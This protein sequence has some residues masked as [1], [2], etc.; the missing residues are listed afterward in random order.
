MP[1]VGAV[2]QTTPLSTCP[3]LRA[4][5]ANLSGGWHLTQDIDCAETVGWRLPEAG[6]RCS[7]ELMGSVR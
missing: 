6:T 5:A 3:E 1:S 7:F 2:A 4:V